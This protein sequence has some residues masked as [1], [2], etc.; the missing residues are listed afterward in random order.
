MMKYLSQY[1]SEFLYGSEKGTKFLNDDTNSSSGVVSFQFFLI[2]LANLLASSYCYV[3][4]ELQ[5][6]TQCVCIFSN[7][8]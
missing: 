5:L 3:V 4:T 2:L 6:C 1:F 7:C 8:K